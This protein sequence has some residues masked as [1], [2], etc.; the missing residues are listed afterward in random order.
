MRNYLFSLRYFLKLMSFFNE[1]FD[2][3]ISKPLNISP[4]N[5]PSNNMPSS[6]MYPH[7]CS[8]N[9]GWWA[10]CHYLL[11]VSTIGHDGQ[12]AFFIHAFTIGHD[13]S[14]AFLTHVS[15]IL[16]TWWAWC[17]SHACIPNRASWAR[18][19]PH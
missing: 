19:L 5:N 16:K 3:K 4:E 2:R 12:N 11:H 7:I 9:T 13:G 6:H 18:C 1:I 8:H 17:L 15:I 14:G 10:R